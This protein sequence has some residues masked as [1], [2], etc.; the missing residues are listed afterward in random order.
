M[1][2]HGLPIFFTLLYLMA[3]MRPV[4]PVFDYLVNQDYITEYLCINKDK[5]MLNCNGKCYLS[6]MIQEEQ[7]EK[8]QNL[9]AIDL[10]EYP[11]GF[12]DILLCDFSDQTSIKKALPSMITREPNP[13]IGS[14][15]H[16]PNV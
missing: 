11:I 7:S 5:P 16:P 15:F 10:K 4:L 14:V 13:Y 3:M 8:K 2:K 9:P 6:K 1:K 12:V